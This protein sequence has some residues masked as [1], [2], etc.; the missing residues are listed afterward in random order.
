MG[1]KRKKAAPERTVFAHKV[2]EG[3]TEDKTVF[4]KTNKPHRKGEKLLTYFTTD[5]IKPVILTSNRE[6][7]LQMT[8]KP[9]I[10]SSSTKT[11]FSDLST[12]D[13]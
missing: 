4:R 1:K 2:T 3:E 11:S 8:L 9:N 5:E 13:Y 7:C 10:F 12:V 6:E